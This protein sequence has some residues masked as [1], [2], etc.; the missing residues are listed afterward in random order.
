MKRAVQ[1]S[2]QVIIKGREVEQSIVRED[3]A[4]FDLHELVRELERDMAT[5]AANLEYERA[6]LL[7]DQIT[8]LKNGTGKVEPRS[9]GSYP[10]PSRR[11][12]G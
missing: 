12:R 5:A 7:R 2:L 10:K 11:K 3:A 4:S 9:R 6:A 8:E 1:E